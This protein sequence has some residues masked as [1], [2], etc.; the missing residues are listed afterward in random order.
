MVRRSPLISF[1]LHRID[2]FREREDRKAIRVED[3]MLN[4]LHDQTIF[5]LP[6]SVNGQQF[7]GESIIVSL[8]FI[9]VL[10]L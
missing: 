9:S 1:V 3:F 7:I 6:G 5:R 2:W 8:L 4:Q 10:L